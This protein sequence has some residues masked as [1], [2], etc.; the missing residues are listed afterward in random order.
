MYNAKTIRIYRDVQYGE[1]TL[2]VVQYG[3]IMY[4]HNVIFTTIYKNNY[5]AYLVTLFKLNLIKIEAYTKPNEA[6]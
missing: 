2:L 3:K 6:K 4:G 1:N 5:N